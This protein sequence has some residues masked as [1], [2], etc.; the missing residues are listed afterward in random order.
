V[1]ARTGMRDAGGSSESAKLSENAM[2]SA[3]WMFALRMAPSMAMGVLGPR[4]RLDAGEFEASGSSALL[5][6]AA[7][8]AACRACGSGGNTAT[9]SRLNVSLR[10]TAA[11]ESWGASGTGDPWRVGGNGDPARVSGSTH[12]EPLRPPTASTV[13]IAL[14][15]WAT[16]SGTVKATSCGARRVPTP[17]LSYGTFCPGPWSRPWATGM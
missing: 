10:G 1:P 17:T 3:R 14:R 16:P 8:D 2:A 13:G 15:E 12:G 4:A 9:P 11:P 5:S 6:E 7:M